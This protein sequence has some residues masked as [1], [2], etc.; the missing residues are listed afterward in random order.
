MCDF[1]IL[2]L[3]YSL[4][5]SGEKKVGNRSIVPYIISIFQIKFRRLSKV[6]KGSLDQGRR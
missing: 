3:V 2:N 1:Q 6:L 4:L 5:G